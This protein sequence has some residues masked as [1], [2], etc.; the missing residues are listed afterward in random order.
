MSE[1]YFA[2]SIKSSF[3]CYVD[4]TRFSKYPVALSFNW[5]G[6]AVCKPGNDTFNSG[7]KG[8]ENMCNTAWEEDSLVGFVCIS[9]VLQ[10]IKDVMLC[11]SGFI[12]A[13]YLNPLH[14]QFTCNKHLPGSST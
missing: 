11:L 2:R 3:G 6:I 5:S 14:S 9:S 12:Y 7:L 8:S 13:S 4:S 1:H 10:I